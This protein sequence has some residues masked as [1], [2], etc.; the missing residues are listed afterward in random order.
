MTPLPI[1]LPHVLT[2]E[3]HASELISLIDQLKAINQTDR[4]T[5]HI[6]ILRRV[7]GT[8]AGWIADVYTNYPPAKQLDLIP[9]PA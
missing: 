9:M 4:S 8:N 7:S 6:G 2:V 3:C 1:P 5:S